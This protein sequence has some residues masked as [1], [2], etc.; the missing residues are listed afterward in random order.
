MFSLVKRFRKE[1]DLPAQR[2]NPRNVAVVERTERESHS[3]GLSSP[4]TNRLLKIKAKLRRRN[5]VTAS[6]VLLRKKKQQ[7]PG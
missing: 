5:S 1:K 3:R 7:P 4:S 2:R 6:K